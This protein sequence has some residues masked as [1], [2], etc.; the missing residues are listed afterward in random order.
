MKGVFCF[1][2]KFNSER[3]LSRENQINLFY[4]L[5]YKKREISK[6]K[7]D[8]YKKEYKEYLRV[9]EENELI[10]SIAKF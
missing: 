10:E 3:E 2:E 6:K 4:K 5:P 8:M 1:D 7:I 9:K